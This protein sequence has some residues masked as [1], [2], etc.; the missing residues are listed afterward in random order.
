[1]KEVNCACFP[2]GGALLACPVTEPGVK[3]VDV[4]LPGC[5]EVNRPPGNMSVLPAVVVFLLTV[6][7]TLSFV[8]VFRSG[9]MFTLQ[10]PTKE[11][12]R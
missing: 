10:R 6:D 2:A 4:L 3:E 5:G 8:P 9:L 1:M 11:A 12:G 7:V